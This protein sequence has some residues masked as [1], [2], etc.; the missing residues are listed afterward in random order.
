MGAKVVD[1][2]SNKTTILLAGTN[3]GSK[4]AKAQQL[5]IR[6]IFELQELLPESRNPET[7][8]SSETESSLF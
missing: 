5:G 4:L 2:V 1:T 7:T 3:P 8:K 6:I